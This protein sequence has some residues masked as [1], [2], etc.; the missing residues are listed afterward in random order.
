VSH[1]LEHAAWDTAVGGED[2]AGERWSHWA[3]HDVAVLADG[4]LV[5]PDPRGGL[6]VLAGGVVVDRIETDTNEIHGITVVVDDGAECLWLADCGFTM[7][8]GEGGGFEPGQ[9]V[10]RG[11]RAVEIALDGRELAS[12]K[13][14][15]D[16]AAYESAT[17]LP[18]SVAVDELR[19]GGS[20]DIWVADG[21]GA[22]LVHRFSAEGALLSTLTGTE[23]AG[24]FDTPHAVFL[25]RR[26]SPAELLVAD[27]GNAR[28]QVFSLDGRFL[29][30]VGDGVLTSPSAFAIHGDHLV[31]AEL[32]ARVVLIDLED[33]LVG[34]LGSDPSVTAR[35]G[36]PNALDPGGLE[37]RPPLAATSF[38]SPHGLAV[39]AGGNLFISEWL[40]GG[41][42][43][44]LSP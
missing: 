26:R 42:T 35:P 4:R 8:R 44:R 40:I 38:N 25:D 22:G 29:R 2:L 39:D 14:P 23:G 33:R 27:R 30:C 18:T 17:F 20:G 32:Q 41:R 34:E 6:A 24:R 31:V 19:L 13:V 5:V 3:H 16:H 15:R 12:I 10:R 9:R 7:V 21:Y 37:V 11:P 36:W 28:I 1:E 43:V